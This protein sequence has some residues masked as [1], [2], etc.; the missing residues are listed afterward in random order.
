[1]TSYVLGTKSA[2]M[3]QVI[4]PS[5]PPVIR[6]MEA[7]AANGEI[8]Y[9]TLVALDGDGEV[10]PWDGSTGS[11]IGVLTETIDTAAGDTQ[12]LVA[13]VLVHGCVKKDVLLVD[14]AAP[15]AAQLALLEA[16]GIWANQSVL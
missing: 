12:D 1:M 7:D 16:A 3:A 11:P 9:G 14:D 4:D 13:R 15:T 5:H 8:R 2:A 10:I 6:A